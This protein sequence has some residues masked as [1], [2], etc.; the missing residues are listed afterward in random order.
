MNVYRVAD[1]DHDG[2]Y[3]RGL[4]STKQAAI[5]RADELARSAP[6]GGLCRHVV[7]EYTVDSDDEPDEVYDTFSGK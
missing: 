5:T 4:Y 1:Q 3:P 6:P 7:E 2:R